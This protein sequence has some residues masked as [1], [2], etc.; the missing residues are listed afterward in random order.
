[1]RLK[2]FS[3]LF[4][5]ITLPLTWDVKLW[6]QYIVNPSWLMSKVFSKVKFEREIAAETKGELLDEY[7]MS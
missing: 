3:V 7:G 6:F 4:F 1:M 5:E 2:D